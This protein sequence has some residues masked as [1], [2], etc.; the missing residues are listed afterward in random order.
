[1][2]DLVIKESKKSIKIK[3]PSSFENVN[4]A[5]DT[6]LEFVETK[7]YPG[8]HFDLNL[9][10]REVL[11]NVVEHGN[12]NRT[13]LYVK[14]NFEIADNSIKATV[15]DEGKGKDKKNHLKESKDL[16]EFRG[17]GIELCSQLGFNIELNKKGNIT[18]LR[19][20]NDQNN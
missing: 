3:F 14:V 6:I 11:N 16:I 17:R 2:N 18:V 20:N 15:K 12:N 7:D 4:H 19:K 1:M 10:L 9:V 8:N 13:E 5:V